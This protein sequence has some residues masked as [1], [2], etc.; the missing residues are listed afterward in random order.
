MIAA[1][2]PPRDCA[3]CS[4][5]PWPASRAGKLPDQDSNL[6][7]QDQN[8][9]CC[10]LHHRAESA[11]ARARPGP[12]RAGGAPDHFAREAFSCCWARATPRGLRTG[13]SRG[14]PPS[15]Q[16]KRPAAAR[17]GTPLRTL[18]LD[19]ARPR[20]PRGWRIGRAHDRASAAGGWLVAASVAIGSG[21][22]PMFALSP[23]P[24]NR[25]RFLCVPVKRGGRRLRRPELFTANRPPAPSTLDPS[26]PPPTPAESPSSPRPAPRSPCSA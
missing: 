11:R 20:P 13:P 2:A 21:S 24:V 18:E 25:A 15:R 14:P 22:N 5:T 10:Q 9:P 16:G 4:V 7:L 8:L 6:D 12:P 26:T 17:F 19:P 3:L 23:A 1:G